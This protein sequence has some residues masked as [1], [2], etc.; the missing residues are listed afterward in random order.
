MRAKDATDLQDP[1]QSVV[2]GD[3][4]SEHINPA[5]LPPTQRQLFMRIQQKQQHRDDVSEITA[6][7]SSSPPI[8]FTYLLAII[9]LEISGYNT[10]EIDCLISSVCSNRPISKYIH[11]N[12]HIN[13]P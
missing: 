10:S 9:Y 11:K 2:V 3:D 6:K 13:E 1:V 7:R 4:G 12:M 8:S 5:Q